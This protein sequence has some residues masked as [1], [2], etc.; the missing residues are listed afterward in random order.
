[1]AA[2][3]GPPHTRRKTRRTEDTVVNLSER[4]LDASTARAADPAVRA[5]ERAIVTES[6]TILADTLAVSTAVESRRRLARLLDLKDEAE[7]DAR[8]RAAYHRAADDFR[9]W[10]AR[11]YL[12][13]RDTRR[14]S[15]LAADTEGVR[16]VPYDPIERWEWEG[17]LIPPE[18][19]GGRSSAAS[20]ADRASRDAA[21]EGGLE[22]TSTVSS[23]WRHGRSSS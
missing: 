15:Q 4:R 17:G 6:P 18:P 22:S 2:R 10:A 7:R 11:V 13:A 5:A 16:H 14:R 19:A 20:G 1:M 9:S 3:L 21:E 23:S 8:R 12:A